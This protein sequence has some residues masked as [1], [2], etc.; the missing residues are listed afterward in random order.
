MQEKNRE[1][2]AYIFS[3]VFFF[4]NCHFL[5]HNFFHFP[6]LIARNGIVSGDFWLLIDRLNFAFDS[7]HNE[8]F[9]AII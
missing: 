9:L 1:R 6:V 7:K 2:K 5:V 4:N 3:G 8:I